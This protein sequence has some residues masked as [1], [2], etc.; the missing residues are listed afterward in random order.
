MIIES[1]KKYITESTCRNAQLTVTAQ[2]VRATVL[3]A[4]VGQMLT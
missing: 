2:Y 1:F 3:A 4:E